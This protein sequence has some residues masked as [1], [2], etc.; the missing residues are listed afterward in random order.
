MSLLDARLV[1]QDPLHI[2]NRDQQHRVRPSIK[3]I[4]NVWEPGLIEILSLSAV[5]KVQSL[6]LTH[7]TSTTNIKAFVENHDLF[8]LEMIPLDGELTFWT[9]G[10][11]SLTP[12][13][14][15]SSIL[16]NRLHHVL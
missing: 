7:G 2:K 3:G 16:F 10:K 14:P 6:T 9:S 5:M 11:T 13:W 1:Y 4:F 12:V 15:R 8:D